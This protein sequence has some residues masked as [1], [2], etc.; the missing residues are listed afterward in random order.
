MV[1]T[2]FKFTPNRIEVPAGG[3]LVL[4]LKNEGTVTHNLAIAAAGQ[5]S[6]TIRPGEETSVVF[7]PP[8]AG[9]YAFAC[10]VPGHEMV[11][12]KGVIVVTPPR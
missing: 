8:K 7:K 10:K 11:G 12:M 9:S 5:Q 4:T 1:A 2:E 3:T 6:T